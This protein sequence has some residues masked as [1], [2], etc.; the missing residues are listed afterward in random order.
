MNDHI[1]VRFRFDLESILSW[2]ISASKGEPRRCS[3]EQCLIN[4][5]RKCIVF[6]L[7]YFDI[8]IS[9]TVFLHAVCHIDANKVKLL[10][11]RLG[12]LPITIAYTNRENNKCFYPYIFKFGQKCM[13][14]KNHNTIARVGTHVLCTHS[15]SYTKYLNL[16]QP[17]YTGMPLVDPVY[18]GIPN[19]W[20]REYL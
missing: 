20:P 13:F 3:S 8:V 10:T 17:V 1:P 15:Q 4:V 5:S 18:T 7:D 12:H 11:N 19:G 9:E 16:I 14:S 6:Y 2:L